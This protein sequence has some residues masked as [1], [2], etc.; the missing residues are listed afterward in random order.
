M[1]SAR[2]AS[3]RDDEVESSAA[4]SV[5]RDGAGGAGVFGQAGRWRRGATCGLAALLAVSPLAV[6]A[7]GASAAAPPSV[8]PTPASPPSPVRFLQPVESSLTRDKLPGT[9]GSGQL[10]VPGA[11]TGDLNSD[12]NLDLVA[13]FDRNVD[14]RNGGVAVMRGFGDGTFEDPVAYT[15]PDPRRHTPNGVAL[16]DFDEDGDLD[17]VTTVELRHEIDFWA[18]DGNGVL[19]AP[20]FTPSAHDPSTDI[21]VVDLDGDAHLDVIAGS[22]N[23]SFIVV[24]YGRGDGTFV[25]LALDTPNE[26]AMSLAVADFNGGGLDIASSS[27]ESGL[28][29]HLRSGARTFTRTRTATPGNMLTGH[30]WAAELSGDGKV[31]LVVGGSYGTA[32][33]NICVSCVVTITGNGDGT[34]TVPSDAARWT[35][36]DSV[37]GGGDWSKGTVTPLADLDKDGDL[38]AVMSVRDGRSSVTVLRNDGTG[39]FSAKEW[40]ALTDQSGDRTASISLN[41][42]GGGTMRSP[43]IAITGDFNSDGTMDIAAAGSTHQSDGGITVLPGDGAH[44]GRFLTPEILFTGGD[45]PN[46][47]GVNIPIVDWDGDGKQDIVLSAWLGI[48]SYHGNGDGTFA[49]SVPVSPSVDTWCYSPRHLLPGDFDGDGRADLFC[50]GI[51]N[52]LRDAVLYGDGAGGIA[53]VVK[54]ELGETSDAAHGQGPTLV[55]IDAD[56]DLDVI[57]ARRH[58]S[59]CFPELAAVGIYRNGGGGRTWTKTIIDVN[60]AGLPVTAG[61]IDGDGDPDLITRP[62]YDGSNFIDVLR[63][64][65]NDGAGNFGAPHDITPG[66][67]KHPSVHSLN[68]ADLDHDGDVDLVAQ[69][70]IWRDSLG[71][72]AQGGVW[73]LL[74]NGT[75][76]FAP[77]TKYTSSLGGGELRDIDGDGHLDLA[78]ASGGFGIEVLRG[79]GDGTFAHHARFAV[80]G[81]DPR[82]LGFGDLDAD[83]DLDVVL[84]RANYGRQP[85]ANASVVVLPNI[86]TADPLPTVPDLVVEQITAPASVDPGDSRPLQVVVRND[87]SRATG[88]WTDQ[89][90]LSADDTWDL[91]DR[92][93]GSVEHTTPVNLGGSYTIDLAPRF[94]PLVDGAHKII[95]RTDARRELVESDDANN[96]L[97]GPSSV[98]LDIPDLVVSTPKQVTLSAT[99]VRYLRIAD[100]SAELALTFDAPAG[101]V[102]DVEVVR[103]RVPVP[104]RQLTL[105]DT[106]ATHRAASLPNDADGDWF[107]RLSGRPG[108]GAG[109]IVTVL[110]S[111]LDLGLFSVTPARGSN[112]GTSTVRVKGA[113]F[114]G[115]ARVRLVDGPSGATSPFTSGDVTGDQLTAILELRG[116]PEGRYDVEVV[117]VDGVTARLG[118]A[119]LVTAGAPGH[120]ELYTVAPPRVRPGWTGQYVIT[121]HNTGETDLTVDSLVVSAVQASMR[122][123]HRT[124]FS[125]RPITFVPTD[126]PGPLGPTPAGVLSPGAARRAVVEF[127]ASGANPRLKTDLY[128]HHAPAPPPPPP[129]GLVIDSVVGPATT[130]SGDPANVVFRVRNTSGARLVG[131]WAVEVALLSQPAVL[132]GDDVITLPAIGPSRRASVGSGSILDPGQGATFSAVIPTADAADDDYRWLVRWPSVDPGVV[133]DVDFVPVASLVDEDEDAASWSGLPVAVQARGLTIGTSQRVSLAEG[134][135]RLLRVDADTGDTRIE[136]INQG[137]AA[138]EASAASEAAPF[139]GAVDDTTTLAA[140]TAGDL[141]LTTTDQADYVLVGP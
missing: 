100:P 15:L 5:A 16:G 54:V 60:Y 103:G 88:A 53:E 14:N 121:V 75:G 107:I 44:L 39:A 77:P 137:P 119:F 110:A 41:G 72:V 46:E 93:L 139:G 113:G 83:G 124:A 32:P 125:P 116:V 8:S 21:V 61:D 141:E 3:Y 112:R 42:V 27:W 89:V 9:L 134:E 18:N 64:Y 59:C 12:G 78:V 95:V 58:Y 73:V 49:A 57:E 40:L 35:A 26:N 63:V 25:E 129:D 66:L 128:E 136:L 30:L 98:Q 102:A 105:P 108:A 28:I 122:L 22:P 81:Q 17:V 33:G 99:G 79:L 84:S 92:L 106:P 37:Y 52:P 51:T 114:N 117:R 2:P 69:Q 96:L 55:D 115:A 62:S 135:T 10:D 90:W 131:P 91:D 48:R 56:G 118:D 138:I 20:V 7:D 23:D 109:T 82:S 120:V 11:A 70:T 101:D 86:S 68:A 111:P 38:D 34:F 6:S 47:Y 19:A 127:A 50:H 65:P 133:E 132:D 45:D 36:V 31:D 80:G 4:T 140:A 97:V 74:N 85:G 87:G 71:N 126:P 29:L 104:V 94:D 1:L 24:M 43:T 13:T 76:T 67:P 130:T 123:P